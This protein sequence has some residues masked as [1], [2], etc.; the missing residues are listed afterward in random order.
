MT[1]S[2]NKI[3]EFG[4]FTLDTAEEKLAR[5]GEV[6]ALNHKAYLV[7][8]LL[9]ENAN[10]TVEKKQ[11]FDCIWKDAFVEDNNLTVTITAIRKALRDNE[12]DVK[13]IET[14]PRRGYRLTARV[15]E[16]KESSAPPES[17]KPEKNDEKPLP[18]PVSNRRRARRTTAA[19]AGLIVL[20]AIGGYFLFSTGGASSGQKQYRLAILPL[21]NLK[22]AEETDFLGYALTDAL[23][24]KLAPVKSLGVR[25]ASSIF[26]YRNRTPSPSQAAEELQADLLL[27]G[28]YLKEGE[29][30]KI[31]AELVDVS[32]GQVIYQDAFE[33]SYG[34]LSDLQEQISRRLINA[35]GLSLTNS[36]SILLD[37]QKPRDERAYELY[38][39][40]IDYY[41]TGRLPLAIETLERSVALDAN[42][43]RAWDYLGS[44]YA[45][46]A[47]VRFGG[48]E[49][50]DQAQA[51][52]ERAAR[53]NPADPRPQ[54]LLANMFT[55]TNR[56][57]QAVPILR[58]I[59][60][61]HPEN[62]LAYWN[63][64]YAYRYGGLLEKAI[65]TGEQA[66]AVDPGFVL[67][68]D[69]PTYY[70][71]TG[72]Y[73]KFKTNLSPFTN[74]AFIMFYSGFVNY[75][76][77]EFEQAKRDFDQA[78]ATDSGSLQT[79]IGK[80]LSLGL[81]NKSASGLNILRQ[82]EAQI[83]RQEIYDAEG[84]YKIAQAY[85]VL[86]DKPS[87]LRVFRKAVAGGFFCYPYFL[88]DPLLSNIRQEKEFTEILEL[89]RQ[90]HE[91]FV[92]NFS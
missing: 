91:N 53:L 11:F 79:Q 37:L 81:K 32:Q 31:N 16:I 25:P 54:I 61:E 51:A 20:A 5:N 74:S 44:S 84:V 86:G 62:A 72:D 15:I 82:T 26:K 4:D 68:T 50:Y 65:Q 77:R 49:Q 58:Q 10:Q 30:V 6:I 46:N 35:L 18:V 52:Y 1:D 87:A 9:V 88:T 17:P 45:V 24:A 90:R 29:R 41:V 76:L 34:N 42:F 48:R 38:L 85:A 60:K 69:T 7:L 57:E 66:H 63:L 78:Y 80:A 27:S 43:A 89:A 83:D 36:E 12:N 71:Y 59:I 14:V 47:S 75:H 3:Y 70:L 67:R 92:K 8:L 21:T 40:G 33:I 22:P 13:I 64:S 23:I 28:S 19:V 2:V 55:D 39:R 56:A 73:E